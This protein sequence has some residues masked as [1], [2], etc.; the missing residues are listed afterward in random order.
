MYFLDRRQLVI[1][2]SSICRRGDQDS[3]SSAP[4]FFG[5]DLNRYYSHGCLQLSLCLFRDC[6]A[7]IWRAL[8]EEGY[9][10][11]SRVMVN[12]FVSL[13]PLSKLC[14]CY[15]SFVRLDEVSVL[16]MSLKKYLR[17]S[18]L[19]NSDLTQT[20]LRSMFNIH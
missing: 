1:C 4:G 2:Y 13:L 10:G 16:T 18:I 14:H 12:L 6:R 3:Y 11:S 19:S 7:T 15:T 20:Y 8:N 9:E 5:S 17:T